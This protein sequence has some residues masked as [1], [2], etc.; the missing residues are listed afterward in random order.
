MPADGTLTTDGS[1]S[2]ERIATS[3]GGWNWTP[4]LPVMVTPF[5]EWPFRWADSL[6]WLSSGWLTLT[7]NALSLL[8][9][10]AIWLWV[11]PPLTAIADFSVAWITVAFVCNA[12]ATCVLAGGLHLWLYRWHRQGRETRYRSRERSRAGPPFTFGVQVWDNMFWT[13]AFGVPIW[14]AYEVVLLCAYAN[15]LLPTVT[16]AEN[17]VWVVALFLLLPVYHAVHFYGVHRLLHVPFLYRHVHSVHH[18]N[19][20]VGP[21]SGLSMHPVEHI[22]YFSAML[23]FLVVPSHPVHMLYLGCWLAFGAITSHSG[24]HYLILRKRSRV[25]IGSF[26]HQLHHQ[27]FNCNYGTIE[28]PLDRWV[29]S[30]HDGTPEGT[31]RIRARTARLNAASRASQQKR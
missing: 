6:R 27:F 11:L 7:D 16:L 25:R 17:P 18:R 12:A 10:F 5:F 29:G 22:L 15:D 4:A 2:P 26:F 23:I 28:M 24:Y 3:R 20:D 8:A 19:V 21:W 13:L 30:H 9:A 31:K 1:T 14:T